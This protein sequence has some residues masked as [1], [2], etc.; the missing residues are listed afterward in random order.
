MRRSVLLVATMVVTVGLA[1]GIAAAD[2]LNSKNAVIFTLDC[3]GEEVKIATKLN[4]TVVG[5]VVDSTAN[6]V[7]TRFEGT[8]TFTD[9]ETGDVVEEELDE[10]IGKGQ[11]QGLQPSLTTCHQEEP[12][13]FEDPELGTVTLDLTVTGFF[14]PR[15]GSE[16]D[17]V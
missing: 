16:G 1:V 3:G 4:G 14:A 13:I 6:F 10:P 17:K 5:H 2:P 11:K 12:T 7:A 8:L 9:P 15:G